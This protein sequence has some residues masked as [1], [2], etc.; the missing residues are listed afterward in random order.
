MV[1]SAVVDVCLFVVKSA[2]VDVWCVWWGSVGTICLLEERVCGS[3]KWRSGDP[4]EPCV[5]LKN[6][7][8]VVARNGVGIRGNHV[9]IRRTGV[10]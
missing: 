8:A 6:G 3:G 4:R 10:R 1:E 7:C 9:F 5:Y 2:V